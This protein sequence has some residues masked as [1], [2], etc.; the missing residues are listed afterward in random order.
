[1]FHIHILLS[2]TLLQA[3]LG[4]RVVLSNWEAGSLLLSPTLIL[5]YDCWGGRFSVLKLIVSIINNKEFDP[6]CS[7]ADTQTNRYTGHTMSKYRNELMIDT[8]TGGM[9][10]A[11]S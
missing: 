5:G 1:M 11:N 9:T 2:G 10:C 3:F 8:K 6:I 7:Y 4:H